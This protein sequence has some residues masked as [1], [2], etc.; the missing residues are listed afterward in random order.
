MPV[1]PAVSKAIQMGLHT[2]PAAPPKTVGKIKANS[3]KALAQSALLPGTPPIKVVASGG[4]IAAILLEIEAAKNMSY[5]RISKITKIQI[6]GYNAD[7]QS[8]RAQR[9]AAEEQLYQDEVAAV[10]H[11]KEKVVPNLE[12]QIEELEIEIQE[13]KSKQESERIAY[14]Q[15]VLQYKRAGKEAEEKGNIQKRD[16][17]YSK[18]SLLDSWLAEIIQ[19]SIEIVQ[20]ELELKSLKNDLSEKKEL[21]NLKITKDWDWMESKATDLE[22][23]VPPYPD[24]PDPPNLPQSAPL[25]AENRLSNLKKQVKAKWIVAPMVPP[26]G[27]AIASLLMLIQSYKSNSPSSSAAD[28]ASKSDSILLKA[29]GAF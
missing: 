4:A 28:A 21:A 5:Q 14:E 2:N 17:E 8:K 7:L 22:V 27:V 29:G 3:Q 25:P 12:S 23:T 16:E 26:S 9:S 10:K 6:E 1:N 24:L 13:L 11:I 15:Q 20:K 19:L 18:I